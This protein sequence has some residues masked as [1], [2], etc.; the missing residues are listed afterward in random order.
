MIGNEKKVNQTRLNQVSNHMKIDFNMF[1]SFWKIGFAAMCK[2]AWLSQYRTTGL[3]WSIWRSFSRN[4]NH[5]A[6]QDAWATARHSASEDDLNT[7]DCFL[8][9]QEIREVPKKKHIPEMDFRMSRQ[10]PQSESLNLVKEVEA[11]EEKNKPLPAVPLR[12][13][14]TWWAACMWMF[15][16]DCKYWL[17]LPTT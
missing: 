16:G 1:G 12:Y 6:S 14:R 7:T 8:L 4:I 15:V 2:V 13:L 5:C 11:E 17:N 9:F 10:A 3:G